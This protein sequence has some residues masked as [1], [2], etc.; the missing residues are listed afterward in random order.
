[1]GRFVQGSVAG[2]ASI[3]TLRGHVLVVFAGEWC[4]GPFFSEDAELFCGALL[5]IFTFEEGKEEQYL[6]K[7]RLAIHHRTFGL[8]KTSWWGCWY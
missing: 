2:G 7:E 6:L 4:F 8:G 3:D 1:M 5:V